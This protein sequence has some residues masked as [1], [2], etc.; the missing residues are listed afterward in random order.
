[1]VHSF[2]IVRLDSPRTSATSSTLRPPKKRSSTIVACRGST[3]VSFSQGFI[4][5]Q[6]I[7]IPLGRQGQPF[8][9]ADAVAA[10]AVPQAIAAPRMVHQDPPHRLGTDGEEVR[11]AVPLDPRLVDEL[12]V[13]LV[14]QG[15][16]LQRVPRPFSLQV[17][18]GQLAEV[19]VQKR[20]QTVPRPRDCLPRSRSRSS[21]LAPFWLP[22]A[23][24]TLQ[25]GCPQ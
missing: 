9:Q 20:E 2:S 14:H 17:H 12:Q 19:V 24:S 23:C 18:A 4:H 25:T 22:L 21:W 1:M 3:F 13:G 11:A 6:Q 15:R 10:A 7:L 8:G 5:G 16:R